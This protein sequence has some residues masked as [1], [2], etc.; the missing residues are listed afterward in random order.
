M[1]LPL[2]WLADVLRAAGLRVVETPGWRER[3]ARGTQPRPL[4]VLNHHT[5]TPTSYARPAPTVQTCINGRP[6]LDGP[7]CHAVIGYDGTVHLIA[8]GRAN[9][10][11][12]AK[13]SGPNPGGDGN[14]LYVGFEWD[15]H[16]VN[17]SPSPEQYTAAVR[18]T[19]AVLA[20]LGR[21]AEAARGHRET[22][23]T[24]KIDPGHVDLDQFRRDVAAG[25]STAPGGIESMALDTVWR[26]SYGNNQTV[27]S[28]MAETQRDLNE[29]RDVITRLDAAVNGLQ[30]SRIPGDKNRTTGANLW[31]D[32]GSWTNQ[33]LGHVVA[34]RAALANMQG[35]DPT[36]VADA[37]RPALAEV[38]GP[39][40]RESVKAALGE[41]SA[42][43]ADAIVDQ[44]ADRLAGPGRASAL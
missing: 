8:A 27:H 19:R 22:S 6:D 25:T 10:A 21:P 17:Q 33:T 30:Q 40:V 12:K 16:G 29:V 14:A 43:Q 41:D 39:V 38:V 26:D 1:A 23:V 20:K 5:A 4:G 9:H 11:G 32:A 44:I 15:Y 36:K 37:L 42:A 24:G 7:L 2:V 35:V 3:T 13:A 18:A 34:I 28:F 31:F